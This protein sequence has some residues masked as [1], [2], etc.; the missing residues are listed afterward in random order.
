MLSEGGEAV[1]VEQPVE[2]VRALPQGVGPGQEGRTTLDGVGQRLGAGPVEPGE[3]RQQDGD[4]N[5]HVDPHSS[6]RSQ[7]GARR[8]R[9]EAGQADRHQAQERVRAEVHSDDQGDEGEGD[10]QAAQDARP[11]GRERG[12]EDLPAGLLQPK[13]TQS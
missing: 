8:A 10:E 13:N 3:Q 2:A 9:H 5:D 12:R 1:V 11:R 6:D 7:G 4:R